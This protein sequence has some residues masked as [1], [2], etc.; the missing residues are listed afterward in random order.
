M[1]RTVKSIFPIQLVSQTVSRRSASQSSWHREMSS[2]IRGNGSGCRF[3]SI[4]SVT[5][6]RG[7]GRVSHTVDLHLAVLD[8]WLD[9]AL[10]LKV[11]YALS[12]QG[13]VDL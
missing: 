12:R 10:L 5:S 1:P 11:L 7:V 13:A 9:H 2:L 8:D 3:V 4:A 6:T